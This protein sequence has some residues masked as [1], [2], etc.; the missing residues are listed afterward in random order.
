[1]NP[2][3]V[4]R[5]K[6]HVQSA[7]SEMVSVFMGQDKKLELPRKELAAI[8]KRITETFLAEIVAAREAEVDQAEASL[9]GIKSKDWKAYKADRKAAYI[10]T[11]KQLKMY[12]TKPNDDTQYEVPVAVHPSEGLSLDNQGVS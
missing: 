10:E 1:M 7:I 5:I 12:V 2:K 6:A 9:T 8:E 11:R 3:E 4:E